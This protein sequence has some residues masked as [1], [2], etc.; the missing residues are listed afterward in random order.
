MRFYW[1]I[2]GFTDGSLGHTT[3]V[4]HP[5]ISGPGEYDMSDIQFLKAAFDELAKDVI[6]PAEVSNFEC[7]EKIREMDQLVKARAKQLKD[8]TNN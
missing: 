6:I 8:K 1:H 7:K 2:H 3:M 5:L 4:A